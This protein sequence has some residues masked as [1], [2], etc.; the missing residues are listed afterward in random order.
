MYVYRVL[1]WGVSKG[2][3]NWGTLRIP[4]ED[5]GTLGN[6]RE[7]PPLGPTPLNNPIICGWAKLPYKVWHEIATTRVF[8]TVGRRTK[9]L[10]AVL[11][12]NTIGK[13]VGKVG[14]IFN[15]VNNIMI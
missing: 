6:I 9:R 14:G 1:K 3:G 8:F 15:Q 11:Y 4:R 10:L 7:T 2:R 5:L 12:D 13:R